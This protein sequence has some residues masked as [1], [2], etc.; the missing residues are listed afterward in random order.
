V[1]SQ[2]III[3]KVK[4][5]GHGGHHGGSWKVAYA[6]FVTAMMAFFLL[7]W[8]L[9]MSSAEKRA[10][11]SYYFNH[12]SLF[13]QSGQSIMEY[14]ESVKPQTGEKDGGKQGITA[15]IEGDVVAIAREKFVEGLKREIETKL[16]EV[17]DQIHIGSSEQGVRIEVMEKDGNPMFPL[18]SSEMTPVGRKILSVIARSLSDSQRRIAIEGHTD[19]RVYTSQRYSNWELST[20]RAS[21]ARVELEKAGLPPDR[22]VRVA[23]FAATDPLI[24]EDPLNPRNRRI[25]ILVYY[26]KDTATAPPPIQ[27]VALPAVK[28]LAP[29]AAAGTTAEPRTAAAKP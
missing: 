8:L 28:P 14:N 9:T 19:A 12:F 11:I 18:G 23:G 21:M 24:K 2:A 10:A 16:A 27:A 1:E 4:K 17:K 3:K 7:M 26:Q 13:Q 6:D 29:V 20:E 22:L 25:S 5:G 15:P